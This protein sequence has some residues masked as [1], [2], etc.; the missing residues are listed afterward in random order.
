M[1]LL[2]RLPNY[3]WTPLISKV[4]PDP[5]LVFLMLNQEEDFPGRREEKKT[6]RKEFPD[7]RGKKMPGIFY[8]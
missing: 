7:T 6:S 1:A 8:L 4:R 2:L 3:Q 5:F